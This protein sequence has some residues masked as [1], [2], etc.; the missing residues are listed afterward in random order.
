M[1]VTLVLCPGPLLAPQM[2]HLSGSFLLCA[3]GAGKTSWDRGPCCGQREA[4]E[5]YGGWKLYNTEEV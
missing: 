4:Q 2:E 5:G 1:S 3:A